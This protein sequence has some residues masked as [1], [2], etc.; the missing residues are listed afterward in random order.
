MEE[1]RTT[2]ALLSTVTTT[3]FQRMNLYTEAFTRNNYGLGS[4]KAML[5]FVILLIVSQL[6]VHFSRKQEVEI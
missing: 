1:I 4:A 5:F 3:E 6:Q 2:P